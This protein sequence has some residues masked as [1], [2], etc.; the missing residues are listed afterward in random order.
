MSGAPVV[1]SGAL[2]PSAD[3]KNVVRRHSVADVFSRNRVS[4]GRLTPPTT[5]TNSF[6]NLVPTGN[7][8]SSRLVTSIFVPG[9]R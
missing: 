6:Q 5:T 7:T 8:H 2:V 1:S 4:T 3:Q 9:G